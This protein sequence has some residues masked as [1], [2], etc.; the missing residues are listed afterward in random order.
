MRG[1]RRSRRLESGLITAVNLTRNS[2]LENA[3]ELGLLSSDSLFG[4]ELKLNRWAITIQKL[5]YWPS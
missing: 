3:T 1:S 2:L 5:L 4:L